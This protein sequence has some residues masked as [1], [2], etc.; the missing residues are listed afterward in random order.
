MLWT[1]WRL[2]N[3]KRVHNERTS[4]YGLFVPF[5]SS[6]KV[7]LYFLQYPQQFFILTLNIMIYVKNLNY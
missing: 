6:A 4:F 1:Y 7:K 2:I 5:C 3:T